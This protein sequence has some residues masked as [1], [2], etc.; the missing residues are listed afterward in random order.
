MSVEGFPYGA[1]GA[2]QCFRA[3]SARAA[4][5]AYLLGGTNR[6]SRVLGSRAGAQELEPRAAGSPFSSIT[7]L[8]VLHA[9]PMLHFCQL[10]YGVSCPVPQDTVRVKEMMA[11]CLCGYRSLFESKGGIS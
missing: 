6:N 1:G 4:S 9:V 2:G 8:S 7:K 10:A 3:G 11:V 5:H